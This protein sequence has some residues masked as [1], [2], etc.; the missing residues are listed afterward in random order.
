VFR[1]RSRKR[2]ARTASVVPGVTD[3]AP[4][5]SAS[6]SARGFCAIAPPAGAADPIRA[7]TP[8][9]QVAVVGHRSAR[10]PAVGVRSR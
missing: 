4:W 1:F 9:E 3:F 10:R 7:T 5:L 2:N 8:T 6:A